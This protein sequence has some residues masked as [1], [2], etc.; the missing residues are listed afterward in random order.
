MGMWLNVVKTGGSALLI[1]AIT[2]IARRSPALGG[3][4]AALPLISIL[5]LFWLAADG[6]TPQQNVSFLAA[7]LWG[8]LPS[9]LMLV[10]I[11]IC[12]Q[13]RFPL[14]VALCCGLAACVL[15]AWGIHLG[16]SLWQ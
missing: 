6:Q 8:Y 2:L 11:I 1:L 15:S 12:L 7:V 13:H 16:R 3:T 9:A 10:T 5:S 14:A 4:I